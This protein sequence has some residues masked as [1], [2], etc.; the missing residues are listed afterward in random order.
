[1][2]T[3][4][5]IT[6]EVLEGTTYYSAI[7]RGTEYTAYQSK[8]IGEWW[9]GSRRLGMGRRHIGGGKWYPTLEALAQGCKAFAGLD[10]LLTADAIA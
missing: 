9:C 8:A 3:Q 2:T 10:V 6:A 5:I 7:A 1:M 4:T